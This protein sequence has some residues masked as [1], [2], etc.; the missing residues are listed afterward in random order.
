MGQNKRINRRSPGIQFGEFGSSFSGPYIY[1]RFSANDLLELSSLGLRFVL[2][3]SN[4]VCGSLSLS[5]VLLTIYIYIS[6][7]LSIYILA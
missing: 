6:L 7:F 2:S 5:L 1:K 4:V 3:D